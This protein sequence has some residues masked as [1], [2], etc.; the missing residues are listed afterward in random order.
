MRAVV[1]LVHQTVFNKC[2]LKDSQ[3]SFCFL[4]EMQ[5]TDNEMGQV[6]YRH[7]DEIFEGKSQMK[8]LS[9][10]LFKNIEKSQ[11]KLTISVITAIKH[12][13]ISSWDHSNG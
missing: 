2:S 5:L 8:V 12:V 11:A 13:H 9:M 3:E 7:L 6:T 4:C 1:E 10:L